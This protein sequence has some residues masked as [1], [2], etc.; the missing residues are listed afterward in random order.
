MTKPAPVRRAVLVDAGLAVAVTL[1]L[2]FVIGA[3]QAATRPVD[4]LAYL[5]AAGLGALMFARRRYP[6]AVLAVT[7]LGVVAYFAAGYPAVPVSVPVAPALF[8]AAEAGRTRFAV[9]G[10]ATLLAVSVLAR[11]IEGDSAAFVVGYELVSHVALMGA[12][13]ALG[14]VVRLRR[15]AGARADRIAQLQRQEAELLADRRV[16]SERMAIARDLHDSIGHALTVVSIQSHVADERIGLDDDAARTAVRHAGESAAEALRELR[17]TVG[18]L[19]SGD[20]AEPR[21]GG[22]TLR[23][24][25]PLVEAVRGA[26]FAVEVDLALDGATIPPATDA[27]AFRIAQEAVTN[28]IRHSDGSRVRISAT[29]VPDELVLEVEDDGGPLDALPAGNGLEGMA[30]RAASVGGTV[31]VEA[32]PN[33]VRVSARFPLGAA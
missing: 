33:G 15:V 4:A 9:A 31:G 7:I 19:R 1:V 30:E 22:P 12:A 18:V 20:A 32:G 3:E 17:A 24:L 6:R 2:A 28:A 16:R 27:A 13:I 25:G 21:P 26:G 11:L 14:E 5:W 10:A 29:C 23:T 8:S